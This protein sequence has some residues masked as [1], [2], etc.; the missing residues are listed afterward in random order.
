[1]DLAICEPSRGY[2]EHHRDC[3]G[4]DLYPDFAAGECAVE[5]RRITPYDGVYSKPYS[6]P[7]P[8]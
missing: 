8:G 3:E 2:G 7:S 4:L 1:M 5:S 6:N